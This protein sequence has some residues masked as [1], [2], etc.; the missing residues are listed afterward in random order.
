MCNG[1]TLTRQDKAMITCYVNKSDNGFKRAEV[2]KRADRYSEHH[3]KL[4][5]GTAQQE[6][7]EEARDSK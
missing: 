4:W 7:S 3:S 1:P 2:L 5:L 6:A